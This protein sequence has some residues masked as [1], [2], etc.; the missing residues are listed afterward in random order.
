WLDRSM[1]YSC[2]VF[3]EGDTLEKAQLNKYELLSRDLRLTRDD[4]LL[5]VGCGWG[6]MMEYAVLNYDCRYTGITLAKEQ[7]SY[8]KERARALGIEDK[9]EILFCDYR[10]LKGKYDKI[11]SIEMIEAVGHEF[12]ATYFKTL[13]GLLKKNGVLSIQAITSPDARYDEFRHGV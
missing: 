12:L 2:G 6:G 4:H 13:Q 1:T 10:D 5:E 8:T 9:V 11:V 3:N 7:I